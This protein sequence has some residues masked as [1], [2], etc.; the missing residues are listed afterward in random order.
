LPPPRRSR[1]MR[2]EHV[3]DE[4]RHPARATKFVWM[5]AAHLDC[6]RHWSRGVHLRVVAQR[7]NVKHKPAIPVQL[8]LV[9]ATTLMN[10]D[11]Q[12]KNVATRT[13]FE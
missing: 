5:T 11:R 6:H 13:R 10:L 1:S 4:S 9:H 3:T 12:D 2:E 7:Q 8:L